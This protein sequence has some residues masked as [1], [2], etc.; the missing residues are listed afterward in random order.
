MYN[1]TNY[2]KWMNIFQPASGIQT[3]FLSVI[4]HRLSINYNW[5]YFKNIEKQKLSNANKTCLISMKN[6][7]NTVFF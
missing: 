1:V 7:K 2:L 6:A 4:E 3:Y 5:C